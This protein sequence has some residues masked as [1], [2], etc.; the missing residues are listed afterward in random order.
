M[1]KTSL[2]YPYFFPDLALWF[3]HSGSNYQYLEQ[4]I[5]FPKM[6]QPLNFDCMNS[7]KKDSIHVSR[8]FYATD[9]MD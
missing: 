5:M 8:R 6:F 7:Y 1:E 2:N 9:C 4:I 3:V